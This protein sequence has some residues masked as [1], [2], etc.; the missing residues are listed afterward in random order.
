MAPSP[1]PGVP[2]LGA[3]PPR[4]RRRRTPRGLVAA[5]AVPAVLAAGAVLLL[6]GGERALEVGASASAPTLA[7]IADLSPA[8]GVPVQPERLQ[9]VVPVR[10]RAALT[11]LELEPLEGGIRPAPPG[12]IRIPEVGVDAGIE[13]VQARRGGIE[14]PAEGW[15]GWHDGGPRP[16][17]PGRAV[18]I[19][20][21]DMADGPGVFARVPEL[22][23]G[24]RIE[25]VDNRGEVH[26]YRVIGVT[27][28]EKARFPREDVY[29]A[30]RNP[31]LVLVTCG[32]PYEEGRG[33]RDNI[34]VYARAL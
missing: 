15:A 11:P 13:A 31:V 7:R 9:P 6:P 10:G 22:E 30:A 27:Q 21:L 17:E 28:V 18:I 1:P 26:S 24:S 2:P 14:V 5:G 32:G 20:H 19:G 16:G 29:G 33:Y 4:R 23:R 12:R 25:V 34:L 3:P 8:A